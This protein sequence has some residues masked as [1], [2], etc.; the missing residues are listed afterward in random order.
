MNPVTICINTSKKELEYIQ[1]LLKSLEQNMANKD[2]EILIFIDTDDNKL[3]ENEL[4]KY[5]NV[6]KNFTLLKNSMPVRIGYQTNVNLMFEQAKNEVV[7]L[8]QSD[9]VVAKDFDINLLK[10]LKD[11]KTVVCGTR[12]E[13]PLHGESP[14]TT[15]TKDFG[16]TPSTFRYDEFMEFAEKSKN[17]DKISYYYFAPFM[18]YKST[19]LSIGGHDTKFRR[20]REDS[21]ILVRL[22]LDG[23]TSV[24]SWDA[25]CYHFT[26]T[27]SRGKD[28]FNK[29]NKE[30]QIKVEMQTLADQTELLRFLRK[31]GR[32][33][34]TQ[35]YKLKYFNT[36]CFTKCISV[37]LI[38]NLEPFFHK[39]YIPNEDIVNTLVAAMD[40][41]EYTYA[42]K[43]DEYSPEDWEKYKY[44][45]NT[46][47]FNERIVYKE[48]EED[49][50]DNIVVV[51]SETPNKDDIFQFIP[52]MNEI[53][54]DSITEMGEYEFGSVTVKVKN[55]VDFAP[56]MIKVNNPK[57]DLY[58]KII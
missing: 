13:P 24:Q 23:V 28:W 51:I 39:I 22:T 4:I 45:Y 58:K 19:W 57:Y 55:K 21:D 41:V 6:F 20:S 36:A 31:W 48:R 15:I 54:E 47:R 27:S 12:I 2:N 8:I 53:L 26:C 49:V 10:L 40:K 32:F 34:H 38:K 16:L 5:K 46:E 30:A 1:L 18:L 52:K 56:S 33:C 11:D 29:D 7:C 14:F 50:T 17:S 25:M 9:M 3:I 44:L 37:D 43:L 35:E 42:N